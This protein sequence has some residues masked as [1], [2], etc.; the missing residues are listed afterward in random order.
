MN[1]LE[2]ARLRLRR[3]DV[4]DAAFIVELLNDPAFIRYIADRGVRTLEDARNYLQTGPLAS[5]AQFGFGLFR[6]PASVLL[7]GVVGQPRAAAF[8]AR[9]LATVHGR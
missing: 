4:D 8:W 2:T 1:V 9:G 5:Y 6:V 7:K 3:L